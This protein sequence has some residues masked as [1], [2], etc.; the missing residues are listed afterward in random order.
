VSK[1]IYLTP[2]QKPKIIIQSWTH[3]TI[4]N[5][6]SGVD[7]IFSDGDWV[8]SKDQNP[9]GNVRLV[10][11]A[12]IGDGF[13]K[14]RSNRFL[15]K[16]KST[17]LNCTY[18]KRNDILLARMPDPLGRSCL[19]P[20]DKKDSVTV[21]DVCV[22]RP[23]Q[24]GVN[25]R[26]LMH[27]INS[28]PIRVFIKSLQSGTTRD[29]ISKKNLA[30]I[31]FP[32]PPLNEQH[33]IVAK[34]EELF[35]KLDA[36]VAALQKVKA[37]IKRYRQ[38]VLKYAFEGKLTEEL[39][40]KKPKG[41]KAS[42]QLN[43]ISEERFK[44]WEREQLKKVSGKT[45]AK[46]LSTLRAKYKVPKN[47]KG[48]NRQ[49][50]PKTWEV[51]TVEQLAKVETGATPLKGN[52]EYYNNGEIPWVT[53]GSVNSPFIKQADSYVTKKALKETNL[54]IY[55]KNSLLVAMYGEGKTRGMV[56]E[57]LIE[58]TSN[59][60]CAAIIFDGHAAK[61][62]DYVKMFFLKNY[63]D[64]RL[65]ASGGVQPNLNLGI[66]REIEVP[67]PPI[68]EQ[69]LIVDEIE[70][71]FSIANSIDN[72]V[73]GCLKSSSNLRQSILKK[74]FEGKLVPQDPND[75]P[76]EKFLERIK[77]EKAKLEEKIKPKRKTRKKK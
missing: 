56:S 71:Q 26:W 5:M 27:I 4:P 8:E 34:I 62:K 37:E 25:Y 19:F 22:I 54:K 48:I 7:G 46:I 9:N 17:E 39:R 18:L 41:S 35:A 23:G 36:G 76:A 63:N 75:E 49:D 33:R 74:A 73:E 52:Q 68:W 6:I 45:N 16:S 2:S 61:S 20:G 30:T 31:L 72:T 66:I 55:P 21:V 53:S 14:N 69:N 24:T 12:D 10:Q 13:Y 44:L 28:Y 67:F 15:T 47:P 77:A 3:A 57:L 59:Q 11:L 42:E 64:L 70:R 32:I 65:S 51:A 43:L 58:A 60:A 50:Y 40:K 38:A 29:R 1:N